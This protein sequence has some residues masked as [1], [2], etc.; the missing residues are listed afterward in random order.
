MVFAF[1]SN[2][3]GI[4]RCTHPPICWQKERQQK[5]NLGRDVLCSVMARCTYVKDR[6]HDDKNNNIFDDDFSSLIQFVPSDNRR[7]SVRMYCCTV[8]AITLLFPKYNQIRFVPIRFDAQV[9]YRIIVTRSQVFF[10]NRTDAPFSLNCYLALTGWAAMQTTIFRYPECS[11]SLFCT[12]RPVLK[13]TRY[14][15]GWVPLFPFLG[16]APISPIK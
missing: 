11:L 3:A 1:R 5:K 12:Y 14:D 6:L 9:Y 16:F 15:T 10:W 13:G 2:L 4:R 8:L 7:T